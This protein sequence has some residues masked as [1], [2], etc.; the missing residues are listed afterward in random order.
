MLN[1]IRPPDAH[2]KKASLARLRGSK[3]HVL[4]R[5]KIEC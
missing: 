1:G 3:Y 2:E 4:S 5:A